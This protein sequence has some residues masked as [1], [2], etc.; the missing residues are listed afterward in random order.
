[1]NTEREVASFISLTL[2]ST[3]HLLQYITVCISQTLQVEHGSSEKCKW[4][5]FVNPT[6]PLDAMK[7]KEDGILR[8]FMLLYLARTL[9]IEPN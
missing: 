8:V 5:A 7:G 2:C 9:A 4:I 6:C 3:G 1:M